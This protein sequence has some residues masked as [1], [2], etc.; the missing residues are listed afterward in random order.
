MFAS[1]PPGAKL[2]RHRDP[3]A[4]S[5]RYHLGLVTPN[6]P[7]CFIDVDGEPYYWKDGEAVVFDETYIHFAANNTD[8]QRIV[9]F[10]DIE[11]PLH[12]KMMQ[13]F[14]RWIGLQVMSAAASQ[15]VEGESLGFVNVLF[16]YFYRLRMQTKKLKASYREIYYI[17]KWVLIISLVWLIFW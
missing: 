14:N 16:T 10:C 13:G 6:S 12:T 11:R 15:T 9:L 5:L 1:L 17:G 8:H 2:V 7:H 4:G 3:Y